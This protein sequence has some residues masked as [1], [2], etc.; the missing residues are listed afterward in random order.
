MKRTISLF[1]CILF[2]LPLPV[3]AAV[4]QD[5]QYVVDQADLLSDEESFVLNAMAETLS[6]KHGVDV[7]IAIVESLEGETAEGYAV[8]LNGSRNWWNT[9]N[10]VLYLLAMEERE[11]YI[12]TFGDA[13]YL[14]SDDTLDQL[15]Y[16]AASYFSEGQWY[17]GFECYLADLLPAYLDAGQQNSP[18]YSYDNSYGYY[19]KPVP[20]KSNN[21]KSIISVLPFSALIGLAAA[22]VTILIMRYSMNTKRRQRSAGDYLT[23][24]S[25]HLRTHQDIFLYSN[26]SKVRRQQNTSS[27][28]SIHRS[29]GT[30]SHGGRGGKF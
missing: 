24:G 26:I 1:L 27:G 9:D 20:H 8:S 7:L 19:E 10:A 30:G 28:G 15:G 12:A 22:T 5:V 21:Q 14:L 6:E 2:L 29:S 3:S 11:W 17:E 13:I 4:F 25:Y 18:I 16:G 23:Q